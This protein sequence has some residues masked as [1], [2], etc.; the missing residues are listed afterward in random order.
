[1]QVMT[2]DYG[3]IEI[4]FNLE[5]ADRKTLGIK[6]YPDASVKVIAPLETKKE[7][8]VEKVKSK[9]KWI[10][11]QQKKYE[12]FQP[13][14]PARIYKNG[15]THLYLG[16]QYLLKIEKADV[17]A[18]KLYRGKMMVYTP[19]TSSE[20]VE[21]IV[22]NWYRE[23][24]ISLFDIVLENKLPLLSKYEII[25]PEIVV[26]WM[27][28]RWGSCTRNGKITLNPEMIKAPKACIEY[29][30]VHE[31]CHL[32][33]HNHTR[34]FYDL[35]SRMFPDWQKWKDKLEKTLA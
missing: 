24:A 32:V 25:K 26:R 1:M 13:G 10:L 19:K 29:V 27:E 2:V 20:T 17:V 3:K 18:V 28:K 21:K 4:N 15:E 34:D 5:F 33:H 14:I 31:L 23:K 16:R 22:K 7:E 8:V 9:A 12:S 30:M 6:V 35:Q 11:K